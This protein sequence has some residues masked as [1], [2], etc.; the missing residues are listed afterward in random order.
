LE[1]EFEKLKK[2]NGTVWY[3]RENPEAEAPP[4]ALA[5]ISAVA[6]AKLSVILL[7]V[8]FD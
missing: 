8:D 4:Q 7:E 2:V 1:Q 6:K 3:Y 5:V